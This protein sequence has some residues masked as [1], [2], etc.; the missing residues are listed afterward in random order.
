MTEPMNVKEMLHQVQKS[1]EGGIYVCTSLEVLSGGTANFVYRGVL[2]SPLEDGATTIIIKHTEGY[3]AMHPGFKLTI[4]RCTYE[5]E[6]LT[7][8]QA[9][10]PIPTNPSVTIQTPKLHHFSATTNTQIYTDF[11]SST[12]L[13][14]YI[15]TH[16]L[17]PAQA[18]RLGTALGLWTRKFHDWAAAPEQAELRKK[19]R[20]NKEMRNLKFVV[21]YERL[22]DTIANYPDLL[23]DCRGVFESVVGEMRG[24]MERLEREG[25]GGVLIHGDF[26]SGNV[27][28]PNTPFPSPNQPLNLCVIDWELSHLSLHAFDLGQ[29]IAELYELKHFKDIDAGLWIIDSFVEGYGVIDENL[30]FRTAVHVGCHLICWGS[31]V[32][33]WGTEEQVR[34]VVEVGREFVRRGW[35]RDGDYFRAGALKGLFVGLG[36]SS[37]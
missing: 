23:E 19:M 10:P 21:N 35:E 16:T 33:G 37:K 7:S 13:K 24:V 5:Q 32:P 2:A 3:V 17:T 36:S 1:L 4:D 14:S 20:D 22:V 9:L 29:M 11:P 30:A 31:R 6:I 27:L 12:H 26:W 18:S 8:L 25:G 15:L 28:L 34:S